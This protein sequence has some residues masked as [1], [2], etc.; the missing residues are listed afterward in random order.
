MGLS[1]SMLRKLVRDGALPSVRVGAVPLVLVADLVA[2]LEAHRTD[3]R[4]EAER[5]AADLEA[6]VRGATG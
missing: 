6:R 2:F 4:G 1:T 5:I 3:P